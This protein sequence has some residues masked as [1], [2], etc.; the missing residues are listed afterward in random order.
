MNNENFCHNL[1]Q[2]GFDKSEGKIISLRNKKLKCSVFK[3]LE[4]FQKDIFIF[5][6]EEIL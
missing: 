3:Y 5:Y 1:V 4:N 2:F 6:F